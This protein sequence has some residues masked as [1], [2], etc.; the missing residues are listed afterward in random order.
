MRLSRYARAIPGHATEGD[1]W[2]IWVSAGARRRLDLLTRLAA[3]AVDRLLQQGGELPPDTAVLVATSYGAVESTFKFAQSI[4]TYGDAGGSST[5]FTTSVHN[6][7]AAAIG[8][9][10]RLRGPTTT[11]SQ[12]ATG[13]LAALRFAHCLVETGR[14][15][16]ALVLAGE[17][18]NDWSRR[19]VTTLSGARWSIG[20][21]MIGCVVEAGDGPGRTLSLRATSAGRCLTGGPLTAAESQL[22]AA[23]GDPIVAAD[24]LGAWWPGC[25]LAGLEWSTDGAVVLTEVEGERR[26]RMG[27]GPLI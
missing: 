13:P 9:L 19:V 20:D 18:H 27:I 22:V 25:G 14:A 15:P 12:G 4:S 26:E 16:A 3:A 7:C 10:L 2:P 6:S 5:S 17:R 1:A 24:R 11:I 21:G 8:E 23:N